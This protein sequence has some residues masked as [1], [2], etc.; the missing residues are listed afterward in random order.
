MIQMQFQ[1]RGNTHLRS[2]YWK[3]TS[4]NGDRQRQGSQGM[5]NSYQDKG[6]GKLSRVCQLLQTVYKE[7][8]SY[9]KTS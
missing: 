3:R 1:Y 5:E 9:G 4:S 7:F 6:G 2:S 8:Q